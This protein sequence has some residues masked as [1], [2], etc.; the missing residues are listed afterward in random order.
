MDNLSQMVL[1]GAGGASKFPSGDTWAAVTSFTAS[2]LWGVANNGSVFTTRQSYSSNVWYSSNGRS[3]T[4]NS[5]ATNYTAAITWASG[6]GLFVAV[7]AQSLAIATSPDGVTWTNRGS[8]GTANGFRDVVWAGS[9]GLLV[10]V[11]EGG[12]ISTSPNGT[13]WTTRTSGVTG[14]IHSVAWS[15]SRLVAVVQSGQIL[16][17]TDGI[18]WT[19]VS[20]GSTF[21]GVAWS[22]TLSLFVAVAS[23]TTYETSPDGV[24]WTSRYASGTSNFGQTKVRWLNNQFVTAGSFGTGTIKRSLTGT[25]WTDI[26]VSG[27]SSFVLRDFA[28]SPTALV[29]IG[30]AGAV[31]ISPP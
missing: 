4:S 20:L 5:T 15:G 12:Q 26:S 28:A 24:T 2:D 3:W 1:A 21:W 23:G 11:G 10:A 17:S 16:H 31:A 13:T 29:A 9:L 19:S 25:S 18:N 22:P 30:D 7:G 14:T 6:L 8:G 27:G